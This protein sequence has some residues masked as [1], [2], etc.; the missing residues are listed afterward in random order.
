MINSR[1]QIMNVYEQ[2]GFHDEPGSADPYIL[3]PKSYA[4]HD[5][6]LIF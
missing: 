1:E 3:F 2:T 4:G 5:Q 6:T